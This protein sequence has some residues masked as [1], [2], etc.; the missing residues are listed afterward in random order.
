[1]L[2]LQE[3]LCVLHTKMCKYYA[4]TSVV[5]VAT[6]S[7]KILCDIYTSVFTVLFRVSTLKNTE[8]IRVNMPCV[9]REVHY[10]VCSPSPVA[11]GRR[12]GLE[13]KTYPE[14]DL[15]VH[16]ECNDASYILVEDCT[17]ML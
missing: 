4:C 10:H 17:H 7:H 6:I 11:P 1:M 5:F 15:L 12:K 2:G 13:D 9:G 16:G 8:D 3:L 14:M